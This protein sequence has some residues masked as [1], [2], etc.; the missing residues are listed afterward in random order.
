MFSTLPKKFILEF[1]L[2][3][4]LYFKKIFFERPITSKL[5]FEF[6]ISSISLLSELI[7]SEIRDVVLRVKLDNISED[8][9]EKTVDIIEKNKGKHSLILNVI[10]QNQN[11]DVDLLSRK[12]KVDVNK[13]F[14]KEINNLEVVK[15]SIN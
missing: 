14:I 12:I 4:F 13:E 5:K 10:N 15:L 11:Y 8:I 2:K 9:V 3:S 6:K 7:D 1:I